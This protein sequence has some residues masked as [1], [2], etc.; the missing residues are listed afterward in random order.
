MIVKNEQPFLDGCLSSLR[1]I[2]DEI[3]IVDTGST[4]ASLEIAAAHGARVIHYAWH[5]DFAAARNV[6]L[7]AA[8]GD[9]IL[10][11][12]A[13]ERLV[14]T[15]RETLR[16]GL[17]A[18]S[19]FAARPFFRIA[20]N[21]TFCREYRLFRNDPRLRFKGAM[22]E[23]I[24]PDL[25]ALQRDIGALVID[26][27]ARLVHLGYDGDMTAKWRRNLPLLRASVVR[28]PGRIYYWNDLADTLFGLG[29]FDKALAVVEQALAR[30]EP[31]DRIGHVMRSAL[32]AT[33]ARL[34]LQ[35]GGDALPSIE[36]GLALTPSNWSLIFLR[37]KAVIEAGRPADAVPDLEALTAIDGANFCDDAMAYDVRIFGC[38][39][40]DL[41]GVARLRLGDRTG[42]AAAFAQASA[43]APDVLEYRVKAQA[44]AVPHASAGPAA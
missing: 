36:H 41:M 29:E 17:Q 8:Q 35:R 2:V 16:A 1:G 38:W 25:E 44:L 37:A 40:W 30:P 14:D 7:D 9:W 19:V 28:D 13:D 6:G 20:S 15:S 33:H 27:P 18:Q 34:L 5:D 21:R 4:D 42:A 43:A 39:A 3:V 11:I 10:Y 32:L 31:V 24:V 12:D 22:H 26:S 23:T